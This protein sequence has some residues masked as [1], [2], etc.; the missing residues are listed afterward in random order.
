MAID[1]FTKDRFE[2]ALPKN[3]KTGEPLWHDVGFENGEFTYGINVYRKMVN[4]PWV[5][6]IIRSSV[7]MDSLARNTGEDS[8]RIFFM[9]KGK[10]HGSKLSCYVTRVKGWEERLTKQLRIMYKRGMDMEPCSICGEPKAIFKKKNSK[11]LFQAC[12]V[13]FG[14]TYKTY[15]E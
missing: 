7:A 15:K 12:P 6:I 4:A 13:H 14:K 3:K 11:E 1:R 8:I 10:P 2:E 9:R 5:D